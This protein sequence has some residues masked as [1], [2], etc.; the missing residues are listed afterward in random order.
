MGRAFSFLRPLLPCFQLRCAP[1]QLEHGYFGS[2]AQPY[3]KTDRADATVDV[4]MRVALLIASSHELREDTPRGKVRIDEVQSHLATVS[5]P[6]KAQ[7]DA[8]VGSP[9]EGVG[10]V[11]Q[12]NVRRIWGQQSFYSGQ[13]LFHPIPWGFGATAE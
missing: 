11:A 2:R 7:V 4:H 6:R 13:I 8:K 9:I 5:V 10:V 12:E 3:G 1:C